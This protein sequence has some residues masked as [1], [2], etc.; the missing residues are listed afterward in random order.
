MHGVDTLCRI[1]ESSCLL[2][3][4]IAP[5]ISSHDLPYHKTMKRYEKFSEYGS[6][7]VPPAEFVIQTL[8]YMIKERCRFSQIDLLSSF[9]IGSMFCFF[10]ANLMSSTSTEKNNPLSRCTNKH[11][12][13]ETFSVRVLTIALLLKPLS[14]HRMHDHG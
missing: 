2:T 8:S 14:R 12:Q 9:H 13:L 11:S 10:P 3:H 5:Q 1:V 7:S 6:F 4:N